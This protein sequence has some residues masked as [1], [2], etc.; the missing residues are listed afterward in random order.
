M[1][2]LPGF[3]AEASLAPSASAYTGATSGATAPDAVV[4][5][6][7][8]RRETYGC[9]VDWY[10]NAVCCRFWSPGGDI[11]VCCPREGSGPCQTFPGLVSVTRA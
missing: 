1:H 4:P 10:H 3:V 9:G 6:R 8:A 11:V 7:V 5:A 2:K